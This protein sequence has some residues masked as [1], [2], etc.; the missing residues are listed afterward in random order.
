VRSALLVGRE[1]EDRCRASAACP[2]AS[3]AT[4]VAANIAAAAL[5]SMAP[6]P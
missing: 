1:R 3:T 4:S 5:S 2:R 6:R